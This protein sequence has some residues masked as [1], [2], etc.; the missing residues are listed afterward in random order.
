MCR[1]YLYLLISFILLEPIGVFSQEIK[2]DILWVNTATNAI[3]KFP[4]EISNAELGCADGLYMLTTNGNKLQI[5]PVSE[6][7]PPKCLVMVEEGSGK[8]KRNHT[9]QVVF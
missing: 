3:I 9:F 4:G 2:G 6:K 1:T 5:S 8:N 7:K